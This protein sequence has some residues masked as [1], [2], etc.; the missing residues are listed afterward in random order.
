MAEYEVS[1]HF[2]MKNM[3]LMETCTL[4]EYYYVM[5]N[6]V[7]LGGHAFWRNPNVSRLFSGLEIDP[8]RLQYLSQGASAAPLEQKKKKKVE[9]VTFA[10][11]VTSPN[12]TYPNLI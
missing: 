12:L 11:K 8:L 5:D 1:H 7:T 2:I 10:S 6:I 3:I 9:P 4:A